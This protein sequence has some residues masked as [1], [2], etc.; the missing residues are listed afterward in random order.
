MLEKLFGSRLRAKV[1]GWLFT[2]SDERF[3]VR[4]LTKLLGE[5]STNLS[6]E[7]AK[8]EASGFLNCRLE[9]RQKY[10][11]ANAKSPLFE[12]L[13]G[14]AIKTT[15][16]ADHLRKTLK[17]L[18]NQIQIAFIHGSFARGEATAE[19][20]VDLILA[21]S[22][23]SR[24]AA[25]CLARTGTKLGREINYVVYDPN[26]FKRKAREKQHFVTEV[27]KAPKIFLIG[28]E[29]ALKEIIG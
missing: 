16:L 18:T 29:D 11:Q 28:S 10:Y 14:L 24:D 20:D 6:R 23:S 8:L 2:H 1:I 7:L 3:F 4:Q 9:G 22:L 19:S 27:L 26:E 21:G 5:D 12:E 25:A 13:K 15:G 17:P